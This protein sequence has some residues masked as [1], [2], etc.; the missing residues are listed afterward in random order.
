MRVLVVTAPFTAHTYPLVPLSWELRTAG[1]EVMLATAGEA[2]RAAG[3]GLP[4]SDIA[5][6]FSLPRTMR[7]YAL[8]NPMLAR[9]ERSGTTVTRAVATLFGEINDELADGAVDL[10]DQW[11]PDLVVYGALAPVGAL[12]AARR[13][14]PS[15]LC[16]H[17]LFDGRRLSFATTGHL[18]YACGRHSV[19][20]PA[21]PAAVIRLSPP[22]MVG[23][24]PGMRMRYVS[25]DDGGVTPDWLHQRHPPRIAVMRSSP[26][27]DGAALMRA[28]VKVAPHLDAEIVLVR[29]DLGSGPPLPDNVRTIEWTALGRILPSCAGVVHHGGTD[30]VL[31]AL[32]HGVPQLVVP[33]AGERRHNAGLVHRRGVGLVAGRKEITAALLRRLIEDDDLAGAGHEVRVEMTS[34]PDPAEVA[35]A[36]ADL[37]AGD[38]R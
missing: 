2:L 34:A 7:R 35:A 22:S 19:A 24:Q 8:R 5:R 20:E 26:E 4:V 21:A 30:A 29:P 13:D 11:Q 18:S 15:V 16:D 37:P 28:V 14:V 31:T 10:A 32:V 38:A 1:H 3:S 23:E 25:Y 9:T 27:D 33:D 36:L 17:T 6:G 12:V